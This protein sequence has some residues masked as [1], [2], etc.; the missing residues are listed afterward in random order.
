MARMKQTNERTADGGSTSTTAQ[1]SETLGRI[2]SHAEVSDVMSRARR[3]QA[4]AIGG[5]FT[6]LGK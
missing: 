4:R 1:P 5:F 6:N 3:M 2:L